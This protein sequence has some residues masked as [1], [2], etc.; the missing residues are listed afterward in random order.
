MDLTE[1]K[2]LLLAGG[3]Y[4]GA[5]ALGYHNQDKIASSEPIN[6]QSTGHFFT[7][8]PETSSPETSSPEPASASTTT[9][10][11]LLTLVLSLLLVR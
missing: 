5:G 6:F 3:P 2:H 4:S 1:K 7:F 10:Y 11:G 8:P 9:T